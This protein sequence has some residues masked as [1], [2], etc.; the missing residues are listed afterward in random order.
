MGDFQ[1]AIA[2]A[3]GLAHVAQMFGGDDLARV[4]A[5]FRNLAEVSKAMWPTTSTVTWSEIE[6]HASRIIAR[7]DRISAMIDAP[8]AGNR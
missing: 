8:P 6:A 5:T 4:K 2:I 1:K 3:E 7:G